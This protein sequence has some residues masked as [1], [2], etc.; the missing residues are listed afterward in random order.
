MRVWASVNRSTA[1]ASESTRASVRA[2][3]SVNRSTAVVS[4]STR[5]SVRAWASVNRSTA[6]VSESTRA[7]VRVWA[8]VNR[9]TAVASESTRTSVRAWASANRTIA[10]SRRETFVSSD[11]SRPWKSSFVPVFFSSSNIAP[12]VCARAR[13]GSSPKGPRNCSKTSKVFIGGLSFGVNRPHDQVANTN[14][15]FPRRVSNGKRGKFCWA[16]S[17]GK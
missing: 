13:A 10:D 4:E 9:S 12:S 3:A 7:S 6:V 15:Q 14:V 5:A 8:S 17:S 16:H 1:V 2:W 11:A